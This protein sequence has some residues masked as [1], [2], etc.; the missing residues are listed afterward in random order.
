[1]TVPKF[2]LP[3]PQIT[4]THSATDYIL[5]ATKFEVTL[6]ENAGANTVLTVNDEDSSVYVSKANVSD[7]LKIEFR[8]LDET[9]IYTQLFGGWI[10]SLSPDLKMEGELL[11]LTALGYDVALKNMRLWQQYGNQSAHPTL[12]TV[13]EILT[14]AT[15]GII[16][17]YVNK[18]LASA[19]NSG[20][21]IDTTKVANITSDLRYLYYP[22]KE[23]AKALE[24]IL[25]LVAAANAPN[26]GIHWI[27]I[28]SSTTAYLC[29]ATIGAHENP[30][31]DIWPTWWNTDQ[32]NSTIEVQKDMIISPFQ[33]LRSEANY[34]LYAGN[35]RRP[36]DGDKWTEANASEWG[37]SSETGDGV[38][39]NDNV[40]YK[41][42]SNSIRI[43][44]PTNALWVIGY[45][46]STANMSIDV[47]KIESRTSVPHIGF[48]ARRNANVYVSGA[49]PQRP[50]IWLGTGAF[51]TNFFVC[52]LVSRGFLSEAG[53]WYHVSVPIGNYHKTEE[54]A[55]WEWYV[56]AGSP[57]WADIDWIGFAC[58]ASAAD[59]R[60][61]I[62]G[63]R[64]EG[65]LVRGAY[66]SSLYSGQKCKIM[67]IRDDV[68][69]DDTLV[70]TNDSGE[71]AQF[72]K[73]ELY[74]AV[75]APITGQIVI[76]MRPTIKP[77]Q[78]CHIHFGKKTDGTYNLDANMRILEVTHSFSLSG[79]LTGLTLTT[80]VLNS[81]ARQPSTT[82]NRLMQMQAPSFHDR[83]RATL[84]T[85]DLDV[86]HQILE[87]E[88]ST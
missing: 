81:R 18:V 31:A 87:K 30:P 4:V 33:K 7:N 17:K 15:Y 77:G 86:T 43:R 60:M 80:D 47:T 57:S 62:D 3:Q 61:Y 11:T 20:Y 6:R 22:G 49:G 23:P 19:I 76:P 64:I 70:A 32:T 74:R 14:D 5:D 75:G 21:S 41:I 36:V 56:G 2:A 46:P 38:V 88:Y 66:D 71:M 68:P 84:I 50:A 1:M 9:T 28:P 35:F 72:A 16:P 59:C 79:A 78:L 53:K 39:E 55:D 58:S 40:V 26:A 85:G 67:F 69:K 65:V 34:V 63:L 29:I 12:N 24:D 27:V 83:A 48:Y 45:Y 52:D 13:Q 10:D 8:F 51:P 42:P 25:D 37:V 44:E 73:A 82:Y 54:S